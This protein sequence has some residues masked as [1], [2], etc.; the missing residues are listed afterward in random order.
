MYFKY[1]EQDGLTRVIVC[2]VRRF[3]A[4]SEAFIDEDGTHKTDGVIAAL[5]GESA[6]EFAMG[7]FMPSVSYRRMTRA[8]FAR[9]A[10]ASKAISGARCVCLMHIAIRRTGSHSTTPKQRRKPCSSISARRWRRG[11]FSMT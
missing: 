2:E 4:D 8:T 5:D 6:A 11:R 1:R 9:R 3:M 10:I 7:A